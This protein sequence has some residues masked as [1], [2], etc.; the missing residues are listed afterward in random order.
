[1]KS[2]HLTGDHVHYNKDGMTT[3]K[4]GKN[5][6]SLDIIALRVQ[7]KRVNEAMIS[8]SG[9]VTFARE[10]SIFSWINIYI[11]AGYFSPHSFLLS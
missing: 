7:K 11:E 5:V 9:I 4:G 8:V 10:S 6:L 2:G 3:T 1:M